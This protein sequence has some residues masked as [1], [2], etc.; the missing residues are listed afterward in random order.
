M[1]GASGGDGMIFLESVHRRKTIP[2]SFAFDHLTE[3][4]L[5]MLRKTFSGSDVHELWFE[6]YPYKIYEAKVASA[7]EIKF[8]P[9]EENGQT[10]YKGEGNIQFV[11]YQPYAKT[12]DYVT[13][14]GI[15]GKSTYFNTGF[16]AT[17]ENVRIDLA[18]KVRSLGAMSICGSQPG[19][20]RS[21]CH[22]IHSSGLY[23]GNASNLSTGITAGVINTVSIESREVSGVKTVTVIKD[24]ILT[25]T[26]N[27]SGT[28]QNGLPYYLFAMGG[29]TQASH[30]DCIIYECKIYQDGQLKHHFIPCPG[31]K[32]CF[33]D[34][35]TNQISG[36]INKAEISTE[37]MQGQHLSAYR[38]LPNS[39]VKLAGSGISGTNGICKGENPGELPASF[40][41][42][43]TGT[44]TI[45]T[46]FRVGKNS[47]TVL[48]NCGNLEW[49]SKTGVVS[50]LV[51]VSGET[52]RKPINYSGNSFGTIPTDGIDEDDISLNGA[53]LKYHYWYY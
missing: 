32:V 1:Y 26:W 2:I 15:Q 10:I 35:V 49:D 41:L 46:T 16:T 40:K 27:Y 38:L 47:I 18:F 8:L 24:G 36:E 9:F 7:P 42:T 30:S 48:Q 31:E 23:I 21:S 5:Q 45:N 43:K 4:Q 25:N 3:N 19:P 51:S 53:T 17:S 37:N 34:L 52:V 14:D 11:C 44:T 22:L 13:W 12:P 20:G 39:S 29:P 28:I 50:G 6:E 33:K